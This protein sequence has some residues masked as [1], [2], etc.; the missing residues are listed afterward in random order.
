MITEQQFFKAA[1][2]LQ[3][4]I[5]VIKAVYEVEASGRG[6]LPDGRVKILFEGHRLWKRLSKR[7]VS[8]IK[9]KEAASKYPNVLYKEWDK[10]QYKGGKAEWDRVS[11]A[12][13]VC[14]FVGVGRGVALE[15]ASY[16]SFQI[17]GE[18]HSLCG[19]DSAQTMLTSY[20]NGGEAEQLNS[21]I[22]FVKARNIDSFLRDKQW[23]KFASAYNGTGYKKNMYDVKLA[24]ADRRFSGK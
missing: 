7:G 9:L 2:I 12:Y 15:A 14:D 6:Y 16:G 18:N 24:V 21:F 17:M 5:S 23:A 4:S 13:L 10:T 3:S 19:Y 11:Q 8:E 20:N 1:E 22:R